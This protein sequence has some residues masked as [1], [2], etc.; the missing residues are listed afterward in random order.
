MND[1]YPD[2]PEEVLSEY[3]DEIDGAPIVGIDAG[4]V[5]VYF[6]REKEE[7]FEAIGRENDYKRGELRG[8]GPL[9]NVIED[10]EAVTGWDVLSKFGRDNAGE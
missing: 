7:A 8:E 4:G 9:K 10:V 6:D 5:P 2:Q 3:P 1:P